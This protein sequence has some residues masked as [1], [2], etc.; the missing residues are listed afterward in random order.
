MKMLLPTT[1]ERHALLSAGLAPLAAD[2]RAALFPIL[3]ALFV[4]ILTGEELLHPDAGNPLDHHTTVLNHALSIALGEGFDRD[5]IRRIAAIAILHDN[6]PANRIPRTLRN[7][8]G[9]PAERAYRDALNVQHRSDHMKKGSANARRRLLELN[10]RRPTTVFTDEDID[11]ICGVIAIHDNPS[12]NRTIPR[13]NRLAMAFR[14]ADR[15]WMQSPAGVRADLVREG[16]ESPTPQEC[17]ARANQNLDS[18]R[19]ERALYPPDEPFCDA[20]HLFRT[21]AGY[22]L[23]VAYRKYWKSP[24]T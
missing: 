11:L 17:L 6:W 13:A 23:F 20:E 16:N 12:I 10:A 21:P 3:D 5:D 4:S 1:E 18:Y 7:A 22:A 15:L 14:E 9:T 19:A 24:S 8:A 2:R